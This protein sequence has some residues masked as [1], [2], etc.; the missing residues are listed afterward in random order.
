MYKLQIIEGRKLHEG[1]NYKSICLLGVTQVNYNGE[2]YNPIE[3]FFC[4][5]V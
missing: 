1:T 2:A 3:C 4:I 5:Y